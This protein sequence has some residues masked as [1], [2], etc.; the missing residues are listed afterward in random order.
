MVN[1]FRELVFPGYDHVPNPQAI[2]SFSGVV[3]LDSIAHRKMKKPE[4]CPQIFERHQ[5]PESK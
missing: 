3:P 4:G 1:F 2:S 5:K